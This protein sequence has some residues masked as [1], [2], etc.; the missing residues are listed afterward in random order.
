MQRS[1]I[2]RSAQFTRAHAVEISSVFFFSI[3]VL[4]FCV[5]TVWEMEQALNGIKFIATTQNALEIQSTH[6]SRVSTVAD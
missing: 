5:I 1:W 3:H 2:F 4:G 6:N